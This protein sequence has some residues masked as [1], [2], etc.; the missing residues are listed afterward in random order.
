MYDGCGDETVKL[1]NILYLYLVIWLIFPCA[2]FII[3]VSGYELLI[4][5]H[6]TAF[7]IQGI[8]NCTA[9][10]SGSVLA[11]LHYRTTFKTLKNKLTLFLVAAGVAVLLLCGNFFCNLLGSGEEYHSFQSPDGMHNIVIMENVSLISG[12]VALY[13]RVNPFLI[14]RKDYIITDDGYRPVCA[15][16]YSLVWQGNTVTLTVSNGAG[17]QET[18]SVMLNEQWPSKANGGMYEVCVSKK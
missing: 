5:T 18:I 6:G 15:G 9:A 2:V 1:K 14:S 11:F 12:Q 8:L 10:F 17:G 13:E 7:F 16:E 4:G 3:G